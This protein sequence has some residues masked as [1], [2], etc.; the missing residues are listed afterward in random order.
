MS[1]PLF[2]CC[3]LFSCLPQGL[4]P[5]ADTIIPLI[6][7]WENIPGRTVKIM[8]SV[9]YVDD[10]QDLLDIGK[11]FIEQEPGFS[12][13]TSPSARDALERMHKKR[14]DAILSDYQMPGMDG[15]QFLQAVRRSGD[16]IPFI[17]FTGRGREEVI[18]EALNS[19]VDF[20]LQ[21]GG[22]PKSQFAELTHIIGKAVRQ[23]TADE[24]LRESEA[25]YRT[26]LENI[27]DVYY[28]TD[29]AGNL[30]LASPSIAALLGYD[31]PSD[32]YGKSIAETLYFNPDDRRLFLA[33]IEREGSVLNYEVVLKKRDG[34]PLYVST[35]SHKYYDS[36]GGFSGIEGIF[37]DITEKRHAEDELRRAY[38][39]IAASE[40]E[41]RAQFEELKYGQ[42][43]LRASERKLQGI[44]HGSPIPQFVID[45]DHKVISWNTALERASGVRTADVL[46]TSTQWKAFYPDERPVLA[47]LLLDGAVEKIPEYYQGK[48]NQ[49]KY[50]EGGFEAT[51][52]FPHMGPDGRWLYF[53]ASVLRDDK[54]NV[55]GAVETLEDITDRKL[56]EQKILAMSRFQQSIIEN[57]NVWIMVLDQKGV[58]RLWNNAATEISGYAAEEVL[59]TS[60]IWKRLY[61]EKMYRRQITDTL[62][63]IISERKYLRNFETRIITKSGDTRT[64]LWNTRSIEGGPGEDEIFAAIGIDI[65]KALLEE[66]AHR[67]SEDRLAVILHGSPIPQ[68]VIDKNHHIIHWNAALERY[69]GIPAKDVLGTDQ[70]WRA[71]Y[72]EKRPCMADLMVDNRID[73]IP[74]W[75]A[76]KFTRSLIVADGYAATDFFPHMG[77][78]GT[79]LSFTAAPIRDKNGTIIGA[80]ETLEDV[81]AEKQAEETL[82][83]I[84]RKLNLMSSIARH[85]ILNQLTALSGYLALLNPHISNPQDRDYL[86]RCE[87]AARSIDKQL[88]FTREYQ[89]IGVKSPLWQDAGDLVRQ[90]AG[91]VSAG[92]VTIVVEIDNLEIYADPLVIR[93]FYNLLE[94]ALCHGSELTRIRF[95]CAEQPD[96]LVIACDDDGVGI[97][98]ALKVKIFELGFGKHTGFGLFL[99]REILSITGMTIRETGI[100]GEGARFEILVPHG[101]YRQND[102]P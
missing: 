27:Q 68:F 59:G 34:S 19:G 86:A 64:I 81:T 28:R 4:R 67:D 40:E 92:Q 89:D 61:P 33:E 95:S 90:A 16:R 48:Y 72:Q 18:I 85:D 7:E 100:P 3:L 9:L 41:L 26:I 30:T 70:Q 21:K 36:G 52:F 82:R 5:G 43:A 99:A 10:E 84:N 96:H 38:E 11:L 83:Q 93:V 22:D 15:I 50:V 57:A 44:V 42:D 75:Y 54:G 24:A 91:Q 55:T 88:S 51:D 2:G 94:N 20:Y 35:S 65:S 77:P 8:P 63:G 69:S 6:A 56:A 73:T 101:K 102:H 23:K 87:N 71:F 47:D 53:T 60:T 76:G 98:D 49:S 58:V 62:L 14:Y 45:R 25:K 97:P 37:R 39:Q 78:S 32:L 12:V 79:W 66:Q 17:I 31:T 74:E 80:V 1:S 29:P 46:G 13:D